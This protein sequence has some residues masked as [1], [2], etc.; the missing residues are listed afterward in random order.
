MKN[1][2]FRGVKC[3]GLR[4]IPNPNNPAEC[5]DQYGRILE[6]YKDEK[7]KKDYAQQVEPQQQDTNL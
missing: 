1:N 4:L 3:S 6:I 2:V 7:G 5:I